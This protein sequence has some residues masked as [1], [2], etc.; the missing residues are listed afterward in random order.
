M[1]CASC[2]SRL[3][4]RRAVMADSH[5]RPSRRDIPDFLALY[6]CKDCEG[7]STEPCR[8][9]DHHRRS[10]E[11]VTFVSWPAH[12]RALNMETARV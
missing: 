11:R 6:E 9:S 2:G 5:P 4:D 8:E 3:G 1:R 12:D 10:F 7:W